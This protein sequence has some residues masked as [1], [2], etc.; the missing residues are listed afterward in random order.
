MGA[1]SWLDSFLLHAMQVVIAFALLHMHWRLGTAGRTVRACCAA[2][3]IPSLCEG[4]TPARRPLHN[5]SASSVQT[6]QSTYISIFPR[7]YT[8]PK[9][10][11]GRGF[12]GPCCPFPPVWEIAVGPRQM[13]AH[14]RHTTPH[15]AFTISRRY[16]PQD[17]VWVQS[18]L[19][20]QLGIAPGA[21]AHL[22]KLCMH[23]CR[24]PPR[25]VQPQ[26]PADHEARAKAAE[27]VRCLPLDGR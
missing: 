17:R 8:S 24:P 20:M 26:T 4:S 23:A 27:A 11:R 16:G 2:Y 3:I 21:L 12:R 5:E 6:R 19:S 1:S 15:R 10:L 7:V 14:M 22:Y 9:W 13:Q 18:P 25:Q